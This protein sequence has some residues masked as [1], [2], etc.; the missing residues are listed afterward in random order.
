MRPAGGP[1]VQGR[2]AVLAA[3]TGS[4]EAPYS[5]RGDLIGRPALSHHTTNSEITDDRGDEVD[6]RSKFLRLGQH[7]P[8]PMPVLIGQY[9]DTLTRTPHPDRRQGCVQVPE[10]TRRRTLR[11]PLTMTCQ[12]YKNGHLGSCLHR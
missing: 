3:M 10:M 2:S 1:I 5:R 9:L 7:Q 4:P 6:V 12:G 11:D 8:G